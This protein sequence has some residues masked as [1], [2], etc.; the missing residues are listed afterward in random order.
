MGNRSVGSCVLAHMTVR[1]RRIALALLLAAVLTACTG[2][3]RSAAQKAYL[4]SQS[5][6][7]GRCT[8]GSGGDFGA[9]FDPLRADS[10]DRMNADAQAWARVLR[11]QISSKPKAP[12]QDFTVMVRARFDILRGS[13]EAVRPTVGAH[14]QD[15]KS[16]AKAL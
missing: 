10:W 1:R 3:G 14:Q 12:P 15:A 4:V 6:S 9:A 7:L 5:S 13:R 2:G 11:W 8:Q 16:V